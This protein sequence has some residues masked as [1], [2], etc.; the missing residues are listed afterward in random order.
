VTPYEFPDNDLM[1]ELFNIYF[2]YINIFMP[3]L[4]RPTFEKAVANR[5]HL[6]NSSFG[7]LV[8]MVCAV[9]S[10]FSNDP[11]IFSPGDPELSAGWKWFA[12]I[13][14]SERNMVA[15]PSLYDIQVRCV[16]VPS[17][18]F[19]N[20]KILNFLQMSVTFLMGSSAAFASWTIIGIGIRLVQVVGANRRE[21]YS[22]NL[23]VEGELWKRTVW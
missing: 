16:G 3:L 1:V 12:Q 14:M 13:R 23:T 9:S 22:N 2:R 7:A 5:F 20:L 17:R 15:T 8:L 6:R 10:R 11:R 21:M 19:D 4:H 18:L